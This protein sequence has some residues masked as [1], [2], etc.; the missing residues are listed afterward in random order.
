[1]H[2]DLT[3]SAAAKAEG[4]DPA[5]SATDFTAFLLVTDHD[6]WSREA[7]ADAA[8]KYLAPEAA[9]Y[10]VTGG[11]GMRGFAVR[12]ARRRRAAGGGAPYHLGR[13]GGVLYVTGSV[14]DRVALERVVAGHAPAN[15]TVDPEPLFGVCTN[16]RR[17]QCCAVMGRPVATALADRYGSRITEISHLGGHRYAGTMIV[18]PTGY[19]YGFLDPRTAAEV[20]AQALDGLVHPGNLRGRAGLPPAAQAA[21][22][23]WRRQIGAAPPESV[24]ITRV[25]PDGDETVVD[26]VVQGAATSLHVRRMDGAEIT[27]TR[28]GGKPVGVTTW[29]LTG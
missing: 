21:E 29:E 28:C 23:Y 4:D 2:P 1:M 3:C 27:G 18:L 10:V 13:V 6:P 12:T 20:V 5:G 15:A 19:Q 11:D 24:T 17:D 8:R 9:D 14:P 22:A 16:G 26:A 25:T 7:G